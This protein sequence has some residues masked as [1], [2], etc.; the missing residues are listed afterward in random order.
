MEGLEFSLI[1][2][3]ERGFKKKGFER[4]EL[5]LIVDNSNRSSLQQ[6]PIATGQYALALQILY[7]SSV[8]KMATISYLIP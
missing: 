2:G 6:F 1:K 8:I 3:H 4:D 5:G 7:M